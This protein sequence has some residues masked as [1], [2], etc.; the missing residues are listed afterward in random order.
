MFSNRFKLRIYF[1]FKILEGFK[2]DDI[3][4]EGLFH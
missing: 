4:V 1:S 2:M 3:I